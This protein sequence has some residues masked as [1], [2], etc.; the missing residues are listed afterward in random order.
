MQKFPRL[1]GPEEL[2]QLRCRFNPT[3]QNFE[4]KDMTARGQPDTV[5]PLSL[6]PHRL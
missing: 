4:R 2:Y 5:T 6:A 3:R 1:T